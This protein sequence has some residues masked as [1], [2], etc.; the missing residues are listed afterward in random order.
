MTTAADQAGVL[1]ST[2]QSRTAV[3]DADRAAAV[4]RR[5]SDSERCR[6]DVLGVLAAMRKNRMPLSNAQI[7]RR[8][9]VNP[10][11]LQRHRDLRAGRGC[12]Y[13]SRGRPAARCGRGQRPQGSGAGNREQ[14]TA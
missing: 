11:F 10:Q 7:T 14:D 13:S 4:E 6:Q 3:L 2:T 8:A 12:P 1:T 9:G 5:R